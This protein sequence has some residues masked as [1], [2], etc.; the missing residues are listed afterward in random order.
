MARVNALDTRGGRAHLELRAL[1]PR[2]GAAL[3]G[4]EWARRYAAWESARERI[5]QAIE[6]VAEVVERER[7]GS[8]IEVVLDPA[9]A[10]ALSPPPGMPA[11]LALW[12]AGP[13]NDNREAADV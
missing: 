1:I 6:G 10:L 5:A 7:E 2:Q 4:R 3:T 11:A 8:G 12:E 13:A 9:L